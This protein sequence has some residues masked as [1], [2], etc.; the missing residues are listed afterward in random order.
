MTNYGGLAAPKIKRV[1]RKQ[2]EN[3][4][5]DNDSDSHDGSGSDDV[6]HSQTK[7]DTNDKILEDKQSLQRRESLMREGILRKCSLLNALKQKYEQ[8]QL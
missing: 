1:G 7:T 6:G 5:I 2:C 4:K 3:R 8:V